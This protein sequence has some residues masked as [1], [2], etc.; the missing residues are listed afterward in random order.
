MSYSHRIEPG[1]PAAGAAEASAGTGRA[2]AAQGP[3][4]TATSYM[5]EG[6]VLEVLAGY[7][8]AHLRAADGSTYGLTQGTPGIHFA[9]VCEGQ[10]VRAEVTREFGRVV[11]ATL[12]GEGSA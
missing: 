8:L 7:G 12:L 11:H 9:S 3:Q 10:R 5:V 2:E 6:V 4:G 1:A